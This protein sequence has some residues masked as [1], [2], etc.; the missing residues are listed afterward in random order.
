MG[1]Y[2]VS[3]G[4]IV[5]NESDILMGAL[6]GAGAV[7]QLDQNSIFG[8]WLQKQV[9]FINNDTILGLQEASR[10]YGPNDVLIEMN[11]NETKVT[12]Q[13]YLYDSDY[14]DVDNRGTLLYKSPIVTVTQGDIWQYQ[15]S[16]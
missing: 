2:I 7:P 3:M 6:Y 12:G 15:S 9:L 5:N 8:I 11:P 13:F 1:K 4:W 10:G 14:I 16:D